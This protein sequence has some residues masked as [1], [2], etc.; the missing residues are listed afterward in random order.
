MYATFPGH[1]CDICQENATTCFKTPIRESFYCNRHCR[2][3]VIKFT[4]A[5][6]HP[7]IYRFH[8]W[9]EKI[10]SIWMGTKIKLDNASANVLFK[11]ILTSYEL[12]ELQKF[13]K[14]IYNEMNKSIL[15]INPS[16]KS[17][18]N[19]VLYPQITSYE[20]ELKIQNEK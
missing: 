10:R 19:K 15:N 6:A 8:K 1:V 2:R 18:F 5:H 16:F 20:K 17:L 3:V 4:T 14:N 9:L 13:L 7:I 12:I 11:I